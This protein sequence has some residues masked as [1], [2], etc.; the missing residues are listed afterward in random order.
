MTTPTHFPLSWPP[1]FRRH[2]RAR[3][4]SPFK[5][6]L[7]QALGNVERSL[8]LFGKN[9]G[10][11]VTDIILSSNVSLGNDRPLDPGIAAWFLWDGDRRCIAVDRYATPAAN[12]QAI[13]HVLEARRTELRHGTLQL[14]QATFEGFK[15]L[16]APVHWRLVLGVPSTATADQVQAAY[17]EKAQAAHPDKPGG[18]TDRMAA[19][20][21]ARDAA[22]REIGA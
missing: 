16:P 18:S 12:L 17:R 1:G 21:A 19:L 22:L 9:S 6:T 3:E 13:Y 5:V 11:P 10:K 14:V 15:A 4:A 20:N 2:T 7:T 8:T